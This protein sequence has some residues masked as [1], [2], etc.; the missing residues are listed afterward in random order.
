MREVEA[1]QGRCQAW[2][3]ESK[4]KHSFHLLVIDP[5]NDFCD[6]PASYLPPGVDGQQI[7]PALP[8]AGAHQ[9]MLR[10]SDL[11]VRGMAGI[12][13]I[14][15]TLDSHQRFD[16]AHPTFWQQADGAAVSPF[17]TISAQ[18]VRAGQ[19]QPRRAALLPRVLAY[20]DALEAN[21]RYQL[22]V[23]P[24]HCEIGTWGQC[25]HADLHAAYNRWED[26]QLGVVAKIHKGQ[27]PHTEHYSALMAEVPDAGDEATALNQAL[28]QDL[29]R[30]ER[31]FIAGEAGSHCVKAS[32]EHLLQFLPPSM[33]GKLVL[34]Q[35][36]VSPVAGFET[37]YQDF[38]QGLRQ[39]GV[40]LAS[41]A[42]VLP[43]LLANAA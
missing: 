33:A 31:I 3:L 29:S 28:L 17:T 13:Q 25:V 1:V 4:M 9:D 24:V 11:I 18:A 20:L 10:L 21:Q 41:C 36:C 38:L 30:A 23:W 26:A 7:Q 22:M 27:N 40:Q 32:T 39:H 16:I 6:L 2:L 43:E 14:S 37:Q 19:F 34:L 35:D 12:S 42:D 5:Q 8:V 15:L